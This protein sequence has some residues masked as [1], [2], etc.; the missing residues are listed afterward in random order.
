EE[1]LAEELLRRARS[2]A[3]DDRRRELTF[4][5]LRLL[6]PSHTMSAIDLLEDADMWIPE[7]IVELLRDRNVDEAIPY[8]VEVARRGRPN[9]DLAAVIALKRMTCPSAATALKNLHAGASD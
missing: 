5:G 4:A 7:R 8:L 1:D 9:G 2:E 3:D 6:A